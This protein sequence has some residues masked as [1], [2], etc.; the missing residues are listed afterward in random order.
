MVT[1]NIPNN[2]ELQTFFQNCVSNLTQDGRL[3]VTDI[4]QIWKKTG[5]FGWNRNTNYVTQDGQPFNLELL[6][7]DGSYLGPFQNYHWSSQTLEQTAKNAGLFAHDCTVLKG[8]EDSNSAHSAS[9]NEICY[10]LYE[11]KK[12]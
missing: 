10:V 3:F 5:D 8:V 1:C 4:H 2:T 7:E 11:F 6:K 12:K 9:E